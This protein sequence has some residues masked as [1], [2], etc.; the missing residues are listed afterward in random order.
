MGMTYQRPREEFV[1]NT[2]AT[3]LLK[4]EPSAML[5]D[6]AHRMAER[7]VGAILVTDGDHLIGILT[8]RDVL[9]A[10]GQGTIE[11]TVEQWMTRDPITVGPEATNGEAAMMMIH[12]GFRHVP[13]CEEGK[14]IGIVSIRDLLTLPNESPK[15]V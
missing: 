12:G 5:V 15:G 8:E 14:L 2:M 4:I 9:R 6:A 13:I 3:R 10:V 7:R 1:A 11:G